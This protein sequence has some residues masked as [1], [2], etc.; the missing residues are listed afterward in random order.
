MNSW[1]KR[2]KEFWKAGKWRRT[3]YLDAYRPNF[4]ILCRFCKD[5]GERVPMIFRYSMLFVPEDKAGKVMYSFEGSGAQLAFKCPKCGNH[6]RFNIV[7]HKDD[8]IEKIYKMRLD[9]QQGTLWYPGP[10][11]WS[12]DEVLKKQLE[13][14]GYI[15]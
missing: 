12:K 2:A 5:N 13:G 3:N 9:N 14:L 7:E 15:E 8:Y 11:E 4:K 10:V 1:R 6:H